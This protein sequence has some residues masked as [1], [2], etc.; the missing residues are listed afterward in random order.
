MLD[1]ASG[2]VVRAADE[3]A[4]VG[5]QREG[6]HWSCVVRE[7]AQP[8]A[9]DDVEE[10][11][12]PSPEA[13][14]DAEEVLA[15]AEEILE[16]SALLEASD[17]PTWNCSA[18]CQQLGSAV[19]ALLASVTTLGEAAHRACEPGE[20][21]ADDSALG[22]VCRHVDATPPAVVGSLTVTALLLCCCACCC[23]RRW[24]RK[25]RARRARRRRERALEKEKLTAGPTSDGGAGVEL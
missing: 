5:Q 1:D 9:V 12:S 22:R 25:G 10:Q 8:G 15:A 4:A 2:L 6:G 3:A 14:A 11:P 13:A 21:D 18:A 19:D 7:R 16:A 17:A 20:V 23:C 24:S